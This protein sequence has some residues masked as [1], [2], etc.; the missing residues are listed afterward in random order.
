MSFQHAVIVHVTIDIFSGNPR[1]LTLGV[2]RSSQKGTRAPGLTS[3]GWTHLLGRRT[4][5]WR[6]PLAGPFAPARAQG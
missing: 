4:D 6:T 2:H 5:T 3:A 1:G